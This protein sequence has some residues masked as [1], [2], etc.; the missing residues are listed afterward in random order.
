MQRG[1]HR[2]HPLVEP[3]FLQR[4]ERRFPDATGIDAMVDTPGLGLPLHLL[5][6]APQGG[7]L[8]AREPALGLQA[9]AG[10]DSRKELDEPHQRAA[11]ACLQA[12]PL[13]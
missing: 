10:G 7:E 3:A 11:A 9:E 5:E 8:G 1:I 4:M 13:F 6:P 12:L 2:L